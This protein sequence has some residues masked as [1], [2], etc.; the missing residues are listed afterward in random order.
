MDAASALRVGTNSFLCLLS[1]G[2]PRMRICVYT[3][4]KINSRGRA[5]SRTEEGRCQDPRVA[6]QALMHSSAN[7]AMQTGGEQHKLRF[8]S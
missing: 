7:S 8:D 4:V 1:I 2:W 5:T 3:G 6:Q